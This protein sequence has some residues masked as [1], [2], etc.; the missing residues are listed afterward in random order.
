MAMLAS[1]RVILAAALLSA[2]ALRVPAQMTPDQLESA[3]KGKRFALRNF[4]ADQTVKARW[5]NDALVFD[6]PTLSAFGVFA[7][8]SVKLKGTTLTIA[9][10]RSIVLLDG[11]TGKPGISDGNPIWLQID[12]GSAD[13]A[14]VIP[15]LQSALFFPDL[16]SAASSI[17]V[18]LKDVVPY[19]L[20]PKSPR[21][22][23]E[24]FKTR[25]M[26]YIDGGE[27]HS[28]PHDSPRVTLPKPV[29]VEGVTYPPQA[30]QLKLEGSV[31]L[32]IVISDS[33]G[34]S[35]PWLLKPFGHGV[36]EAVATAAMHMIWAPAKVDGHA[37]TEVNFFTIS[38][39]F[40]QPEGGSFF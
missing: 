23:S 39:Q 14:V 38:F 32:A 10:T 26:W 5:I 29:H 9:G 1:R 7:P 3:L 25:D 35:S 19:R 17:P 37:V 2:F 18:Q 27:W 8:G 11:K 6:P 34:V 31:I 12:L 15:K 16:D 24:Y 22:P 20:N 40:S 33:G 13:T 28:L 4:S 30:Q 21:K 36:D